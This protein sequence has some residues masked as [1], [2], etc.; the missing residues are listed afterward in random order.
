LGALG[1]DA[2][3]DATMSEAVRLPGADVFTV[4]VYA[5]SLLTAGRKDKAME[6]FKFNR[7]QHPT[8][9]FW[10]FLG[11]ARGYTAIGDTANAISNW[12]TAL[13]SVPPSQRGNIAAYQRALTALKEQKEQPYK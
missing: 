4:H 6:M 9:P 12:E 11:L 2:E 7:Q 5:V 10:T 8:E 13:L 1:R 3:A